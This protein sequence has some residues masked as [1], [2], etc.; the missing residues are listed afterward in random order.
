MKVKKL[1]FLAQETLKRLHLV[2]L[3]CPRHWKHPVSFFLE[4]GDFEMFSL[5]VHHTWRRVHR[6]FALRLSVSRLF[7]R[8]RSL[9]P[10]GS[11]F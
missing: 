6:R 8:S 9:H 10:S 7:G 4:F 5:Y 2:Q 1:E 11:L 3:E